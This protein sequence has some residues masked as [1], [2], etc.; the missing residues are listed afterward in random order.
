[1]T[2]PL[3]AAEND[4]EGKDE[5]TAC[6]RGWCRC[7]PDTGEILG[8]HIVGPE[9]G[10]MIHE[11]AAIMHYRGTVRDL[12]EIPHYHP[13]LSEILTYPAEELAEQLSG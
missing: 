9:A 12:M 6:E 1:M 7:R 3:P 11:L 8:A 10:E 13:T 2:R 5:A 4:E